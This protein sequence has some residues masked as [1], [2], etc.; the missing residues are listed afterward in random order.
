[1]WPHSAPLKVVG[2]VAHKIL[3]TSPEAKF[4]FPFL[5]PFGVWA[6]DWDLASGLSIQIVKVPFI[7]L[8]RFY[9]FNFLLLNDL[10]ETYFEW[11]PIPAQQQ[12]R[13]AA[14][15]REWYIPFPP[16]KR[17]KVNAKQLVFTSHLTIDFMNFNQI[18]DV[19]I[20]SYQFAINRDGVF[21]SD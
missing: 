3:V 12:S 7:E 15:G 21:S 19:L 2:W 20:I 17:R 1:M 6:L 13:W 9:Q 10:P 5:G 11:P 4:L 16:Q 14:R 8:R 18:G